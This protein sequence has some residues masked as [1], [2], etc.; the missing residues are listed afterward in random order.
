M[1]ARLDASALTPRAGFHGGTGTVGYRR[2][3]GPDVFL[4]NWAYVDHL[5]ITSAAL[6]A[7]PRSSATTATPAP[8][9]ASSLPA[10]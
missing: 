6:A 3:F 2:L 5:V 7:L 4:T 8:S 1:S 9:S 10:C